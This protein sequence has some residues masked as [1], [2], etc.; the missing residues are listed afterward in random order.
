MANTPNLGI[1]YP[2]TYSDPADTPAAMEAAMLKVD[3]LIPER[4]RVFVQ[5]DAP[6]G[7]VPGDIWIQP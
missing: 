3:Q 5:V 1:P 4:A 7:A 6:T 2:S